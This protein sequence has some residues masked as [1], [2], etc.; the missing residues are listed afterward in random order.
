MTPA[1]RFVP[2]PEHREIIFLTGSGIS[3]RTGLGTFRG[4]DGL[5]ALEPET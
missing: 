1:R 3:A 2:G 4:P 5:W